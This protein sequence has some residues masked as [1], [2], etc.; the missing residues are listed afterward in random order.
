MVGRITPKTD[1]GL[2]THFDID[3]VQGPAMAKALAQRA[4]AANR[5]AILMLGGAGEHD[6]FVG[7]A[8]N[9]NRTK[10]VQNL[11]K[12]LDDFGFDGIDMDWEPIEAADRAPL[13]ALLQA[14]RTA[15]PNMLLT[16]PVQI[17]N[18][19]FPDE[20]DSY[21]ADIAA[22]V[23][24]MNIMTYDMSGNYGGWDSWL[25]SPL[26]GEAST[27]PTSIDSSVKRYVQIGVP[28]RKLGIGM[29][30]YGSC[31]RG[32]SQPR[33]PLDGKNVTLGNSDNSMS[34]SVIAAQYVPKA[35]RTFDAEAKVPYLSS[36]S[37]FGP[38]N[39]NFVSYEDAESIAAKGDYVKSQGL[40]GAIIWTIGQGYT[41]SAPAGQRDPLM[42]AVKA[43]FLN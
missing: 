8:S 15:R 34:Y 39:C 17:V 6:G 18:I 42:Q 40:G 4:H 33:V 30:F 5:K 32:V 19:N 9:T 23:D 10:F 12:V 11:L 29:G 38:Q 14:L 43:A 25:F 31:Y 35:A 20:V 13:L 1:G 24:Q 28:K 21:Y 3:D 27:R 41:A 37:A 2:N 36:A 7:A 16:I 26:F 22:V